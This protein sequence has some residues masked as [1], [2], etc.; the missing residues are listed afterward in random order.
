[1]M[2]RVGGT[3]KCKESFSPVFSPWILLTCAY[4]P[5][6]QGQGESL[7]LRPEDIRSSHLGGREPGIQDA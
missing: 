3:E 7:E 2:P 5:L 4:I 6:A 1:M